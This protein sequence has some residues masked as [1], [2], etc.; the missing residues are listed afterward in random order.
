[1]TQ[2]RWS[3]EID[4]PVD[5]PAARAAL[6]GIVVGDR[7]AIPPDL[8]DR[9]RAVGI[10]H[11]LSVS[12]LHLAV[13]AGLVFAALR[14]GSPRLLGRS[15][16]T[17]AVG[18]APALAIAI[19]YTLVTGAQLATL[20]ALVVIAL[21]LVAAM[22]DRPIRLV[23]ALGAARSCCSRGGRR[24]CSIRRSSCRSPRRSRWRCA[25]GRR[26]AGRAWLLRGLATSAWVTITTAPITAYHFQQVTPGGVVGTWC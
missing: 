7:R 22:L 10:Y 26:G 18:G 9:W 8:D 12:G 25:P 3:A 14:R 4:A 19:A 23:D 17:G 11:V 15:R 6:R 16:P 1:V 2:A 13:I 5:R 20:R 21:V 24:I